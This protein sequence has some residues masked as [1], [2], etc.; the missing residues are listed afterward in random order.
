MRV[1]SFSVLGSICEDSRDGIDVATVDFVLHPDGVL[2]GTVSYVGSTPYEPAPRD[3][4]VRALPAAAPGRSAHPT[5]SAHPA[6]S[7]RQR[8][9]RAWPV[10]VVETSRTP[11]RHR[12]RS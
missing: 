9:R 8:G 10:H 4:P 1:V 12:P 2:A 7:A 5:R 11:A 3:R 6:R